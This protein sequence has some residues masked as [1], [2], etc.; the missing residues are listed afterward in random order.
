MPARI[1]R[2]TSN[3]L[4]AINPNDIESISVLKDA[5]A[6]SVY[7]SRAANGVILITTKSGKE[8]KTKIN[9]RTSTGIDRLA[10]DNHY[11]PMSAAQFLQFSRDAVKNA[12]MDPDDPANGNYYFPM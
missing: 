8:G 10:N 9:F 1:I 2:N 4:A 5:A 11:G 7:G 3:P 12:G 6:A